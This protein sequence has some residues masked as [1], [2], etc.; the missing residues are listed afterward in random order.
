V[1]L[2]LIKTSDDTLAPIDEEG[3]AWFRKVKTGALIFA[4]LIRPRNEKF[5]RKFF[6]MLD[7]AFDAW[8]PEVTTYLPASC[9]GDGVWI[10]DSDLAYIPPV[11]D[12]E[13]FRE[14]LII[15]A[16]FHNAFYNVNGGVRLKAKSM[17]FA[18]MDQDQF[19]EL[20]SAVANVVLQKVLKNYTYGDLEQT[21][22]RVLR[23]C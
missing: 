11:K 4:D 12:K 2:H 16:G 23:L 7:V 8:E 17:S 22:E 20:Y 10:A 15:L 9:D 3:L 13:S 14:E 5:H 18:S 21:V 6:V 19:E 1:K